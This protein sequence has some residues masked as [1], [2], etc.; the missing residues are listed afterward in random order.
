MRSEVFYWLVNMSVSAS[1]TGLMISLIGAI[2][3]I[4]RKIICALW[5]I[6]FLRMWI[7]IGM[8]SKYS[9]MSI[10]S[11][12]TAKTVPVYEGNIDFSMTNFVMGADT[13]FPFTYKA[14]ALEWV[15]KAAMLIWMIVVV[16]LAAA[17]ITV[18]FSAKT[19]RKNARH[20]RDNIYISNQIATPTVYGLIHPQ[21]LLPREYAEDDFKLILMHETAHIKRKDNL[22]RIV[23]LAT[24]CV[25]WFN[26]LTWL[27][28]KTFL[29]NM[30][31]ACDEAVLKQ[32]TGEE[33]NRYAEMLLHC[34]E[35]KSLY[36]SAFGGAKLRVRMERILSYKK[37]SALS[38]LA[39]VT[40]SILVGY[41]LLTNAK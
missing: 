32:C 27:F 24:A 2:H 33:K 1:I 8:N 30:E 22:W 11:K 26:P 21:I 38:M 31:L 5:I 19:E 17:M 10:L 39:C 40:F 20:L 23:A 36:A 29:T 25:H 6:P 35:S 37:L 41:V 9:L 14:A 12:F 34:A 4:P 16:A 28:L 15:F 7:P 3:K 18:Y 13:Y